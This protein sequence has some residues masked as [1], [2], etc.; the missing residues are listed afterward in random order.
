[1]AR[2]GFTDAPSRE[3]AVRLL[4]EARVITI[5]GGSFGPGGEGH[6]HLSYGGTEEEI[7]AALDRIDAWLKQT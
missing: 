3:T 1:M 5:T 2:Y 4:N 7:E 6:L